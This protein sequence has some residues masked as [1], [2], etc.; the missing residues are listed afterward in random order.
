[1]VTKRIG[2]NVHLRNQESGASRVVHLNKCKS[3][4]N[5]GEGVNDGLAWLDES[6][7]ETGLDGNDQQIDEGPDEV[8]L[9]EQET[10]SSPINPQGLLGLG[11]NLSGTLTITCLREKGR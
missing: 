8:E 6:T 4:P 1:M 2:V 10:R 3:I 7:E 9:T 11:E 5:Y